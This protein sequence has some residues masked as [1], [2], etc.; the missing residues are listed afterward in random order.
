[1][2]SHGIPLTR[3]NY[4]RMNHPELN[5]DEP[6]PA[7]LEAELPREFQNWPGEE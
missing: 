7:E 2:K 3:E 5:P 1:M 6:L 4:L